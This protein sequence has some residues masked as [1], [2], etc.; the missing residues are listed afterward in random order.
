ML[1]NAFVSTV[2]W[3]KY[4]IH[5]SF[6]RVTYQNTRRETLI[7]NLPYRIYPHLKYKC[8]LSHTDTLVTMRSRETT[9]T[10]TMIH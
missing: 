9:V 7:V 8:S 4:E 5:Y 10:Y 1:R 3:Y 2:K 6:L